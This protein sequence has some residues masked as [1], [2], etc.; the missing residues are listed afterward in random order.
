MLDKKI[1]HS[2]YLIKK[3][4]VENENFLQHIESCDHYSIPIS[5]HSN[6]DVYLKIV[7]SKKNHTWSRLLPTKVSGIVWNKYR[8]QSFFGLLLIKVEDRLFA[9]TSGF[10][11][12][13]LHPFS[14]ENRFGFKT[15]LNSIDPQTIQ[16]LSKTTLTQN[17]KTSIEQVSKGVNLGQFGIDG[18][19]DLILRV[20]GRS[21][22]KSL[23]LSLDG[24]D[25]LKISVTHELKHLPELLFKCL[26]FYNSSEYKQYFP[27]IDNL[28]L[29]KDKEQKSYLNTE[30]QTQLNKELSKFT[31]KEELSGNVW[32]S[33]PE[34]ITNDDYECF[35]YKKTENA[36]RY[37]DI[38]LENI[39]SECYLRRNG[40]KKDITISSLKNDYI[41]FRKADGTTYP[42][43]RALNC[44]NAIFELDQ[45]KYFFIEGKWFRA[46][47]SYIN[48][49]DKKIDRIPSSKL[50]FENWPQH[51]H[52]KDYLQS[53]PLINHDKYQVLDRNNIYIKGQSEVP[54][55]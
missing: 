24:E 19:T 45:E 44:I 18:F 5:G 23:G 35:T 42:K 31:S 13:L 34:I 51:V 32:A 21:K 52:E 9:I 7:P 33:I 27:E 53:R 15:V 2:I 3:D 46:S 1:T 6:A 40:T 48:T 37:Y 8:T 29:V 47:V 11:R 36:L 16:Q 14:T 4:Y 17:P 10:G 25:A 39:F 50:N 22:I 43:W 26:K 28:A 20:K 30:L 54:P 41:Y 49:L 38:E 12:Y 55:V